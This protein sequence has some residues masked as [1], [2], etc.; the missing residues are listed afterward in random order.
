MASTGEAISTLP[1]PYEQFS[2]L[3]TTQSSS[4]I[5]SE[6]DTKEAYK[7]EAFNLPV[8][9][10]PIDTDEDTVPTSAKLPG[11]A[12]PVATPAP[13]ESDDWAREPVGYSG[14]R[15]QLAFFLDEVS[16]SPWFFDCVRK[17]LTP[18]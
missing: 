12:R 1:R 13:G 4:D 18:D 14:V 9:S 2:Q 16:Y 8:I 6:D 17:C 5:Q 7:V 11:S 3:S 15:V 10:L